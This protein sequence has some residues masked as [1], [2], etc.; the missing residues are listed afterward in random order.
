MRPGRSVWGA[1]LLGWQRQ[2][3]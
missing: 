3:L 1:E 2:G